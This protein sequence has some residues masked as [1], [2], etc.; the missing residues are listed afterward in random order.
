MNINTMIVC[1]TC[2]AE[3]HCRIGMS[4]RRFQ[5]LSFLCEGCG[6]AIE[7]DIKD[8][9]GSALRNAKEIPFERDSIGKNNRFFIDLHLDFPI[10]S[11][12]Y[13]M[14]R[15]PYLVAS[16]MVDKDKIFINGI[17]AVEIFRIRLDFLNHFGERFNEVKQLLKLYSRSNKELFRRKAVEFL[18]EEHTNSLAPQDINALLYTVL[19]RV[20]L[21]FLEEETVREVSSR[22]PE[23]IIHL[24]QTHREKL[25][26]FYNYIKE[27]GFL[28]GLQR[29]CLSLYG[30]I[31][32]LELYLR[33]AIFLD[34]C[35]GQESKKSSAKISK[36]G[37][38]TCKDM[39]KDLSEV[40]G[41]QLALV[42]GINNLI[43]RGDHNAFLPSKD[44][45]ALSS[46]D[47][48]ANKVLSEK[49]KYLD[50]CWYKLDDG[51]LDTDIRNSIAHHTFEF[52][53]L[54]QMITCY[55]SKEGLRQENKIE[56]NFLTFMRMI[57]IQFRE[58]HYLHHLI[59]ALYYYEYLIINR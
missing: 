15:T 20:T 11:Q 23:I 5:P 51:L 29:D 17:P 25:D 22:Y 7:I 30:R 57:L 8:M 26:E 4:N 36:L 52:N 45:P 50:D 53:D 35:S 38:D 3:T 56:I 44:G 10:W 31:F 42:A 59:K 28:N 32:E 46:L 49:L 21:A 41:R 24:A 19:S 6:V 27:T 13:V 37:F 16:G 14:G 54:T 34:F 1:D 47:K 58:M 33:P 9:G 48:F 55:P 18:E 43:H 39:Y 12:T 2:G 40:V